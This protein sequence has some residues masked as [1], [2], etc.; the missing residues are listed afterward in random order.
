MVNYGAVNAAN[1]DGGMSSYMVYEN[2]II[3]EPYLLYEPR[4]V[5]TSWLVSRV[6]G[7]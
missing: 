3:T 2:E 6:E 5:A 7:E 4:N 1:L